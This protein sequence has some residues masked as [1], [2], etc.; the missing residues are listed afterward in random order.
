MIELWRNANYGIE[1][2]G[3]M[4]ISSALYIVMHG[5]EGLIFI[6]ASIFSQ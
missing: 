4:A 1:C 5:R 2:D 3:L 6:P